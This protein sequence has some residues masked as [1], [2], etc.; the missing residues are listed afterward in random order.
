MTIP[1]KTKIIATIG[2][3]C[4]NE[5]SL[6][7]MITAGMD[8]ARLNL[9][10]GTGKD[11]SDRVE[12]IRAAARAV[13][14][15]VAIMADTRGIEI[16]TGSLKED[17][18]EL[19]SGESFN[20]YSDER[21]GDKNGI[22]TTY[23]TLHQEV[24]TGVPILLDDGAM[25]LEVV[26]I[27]D[28]TI[29]CRVVHG[30]I[31]RANKGVNLPDTQ[32]SMSAVSANKRQEVIDEMTFAA[33]HDIEY[34]AASFIQTAEDIHQ[35]REVLANLNAQVPIIAK[36]ENKAGVS[37]LEEIVEAADGIMVARGDLGV[38]LP[39]ADVPSMQK[40]II[41][42]TVTKGKPVITATQMLSSMENN[43]KPTRAEAS[44]VANAILDGTSAVML[45]GETAMGKYSVSAV[46]TMANLA[47]R[48]ELSLE[49]YGYLQKIEPH[50]SNQITEAISQASIT[51][52]KHLKA[53]VIFSL[54]ETGFSS[55]LVSKHRPSCSILA[56]TANKLVAT[57]LSLN[58]GVVPMLYK[59]GLND[60]EKIT[61]GIAQAKSMGYVLSGDIVI[62]T[63]GHRQKSGGTDLI[64]VL[65]VD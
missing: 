13:N 34:V 56:L 2:P 49:E 62:V 4:D 23:S 37:N 48:A 61:F 9:S 60:D 28:S 38:E 22:S 29:F 63:A 42:S 15:Q 26:E 32:L 44:D 31:L 51:M 58:W 7:Q 19:C 27:S 65:T 10:F 30:G 25:E 33:Q 54:S 21:V 43:P 55:R 50:P 24:E 59:Q 16:R 36:I 5:E 47:Q 3:A 20:L 39:L 11:Q 17:F 53:A 8:V 1:R 52:A 46:L 6:K 12:R 57:R 41:R 64:R 45:S 18:I 35:I 14:Q 40:R